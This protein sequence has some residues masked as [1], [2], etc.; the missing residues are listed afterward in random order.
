MGEHW[1][2]FMR[3]IATDDHMF[4][5]FSNVLNIP[6]ISHLM[7]K[8]NLTVLLKVT[9]LIVCSYVLDIYNLLTFYISSLHSMY[10]KRLQSSSRPF[11]EIR[12]LAT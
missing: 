11:Q 2:K 4:E 12:I 5:I 7:N 6:V 10:C 1:K 8:A 3:Y 9:Q